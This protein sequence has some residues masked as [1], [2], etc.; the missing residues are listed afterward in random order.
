MPSSDPPRIKIMFLDD[1]ETVRA[2]ISGTLCEEGNVET[3]WLLTCQEILVPIN[4]IWVELG[5]AQTNNQPSQ[6]NGVVGDRRSFGSKDAPK[7]RLFS[8]P[9]EPKGSEDCKHFKS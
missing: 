1:P 7:D 3:K 9:L 4:E 6:V 5:K 2:K 8:V